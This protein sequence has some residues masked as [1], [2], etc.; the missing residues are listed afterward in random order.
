MSPMEAVMSSLD[1]REFDFEV[2]L[3]Q[4]DSLLIIGNPL[5]NSAVMVN[6]ARGSSNKEP[7]AELFV[8]LVVS[9]DGSRE[10]H[11][12]LQTTQHIAVGTELLI[13][14]RAAFWR[15]WARHRGAMKMARERVLIDS[16]I[17]PGC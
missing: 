5:L 6:D 2:L 4:S 7:N 3:S 14:Y 11:V 1:L 16:L 9:I 15:A 17:T 8:A 12:M 13:N 10:L